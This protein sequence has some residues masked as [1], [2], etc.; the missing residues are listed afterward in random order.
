M[1]AV[2]GIREGGWYPQKTAGFCREY[3]LLVLRMSTNESARLEDRTGLYEVQRSVQ[4]PSSLKWILGDSKRVKAFYG[5][6]EREM[7]P[8]RSIL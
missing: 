1:V 7:I 8:T 4:R 2:V 6:G 3:L 5:E